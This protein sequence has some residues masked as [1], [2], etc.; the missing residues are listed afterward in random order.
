M[1]HEILVKTGRRSE[2]VSIT[3][4]VQEIVGKSGV[5]T[6]ICIIFVPHTTAGVVVNESYD[7]D[8]KSDIITALERLVPRSASYA[9]AEGNAPAHIMGSLVGSSETLC[10]EG[11]RLV[12]GRWQG[13]FFAEF[14]GPRQRRVLVQVVPSVEKE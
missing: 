12:L 6:G 9:H 11:G 1:A 5:N 13:V 10:V 7:P 8:V 14:D 3:T 4:D 2:L